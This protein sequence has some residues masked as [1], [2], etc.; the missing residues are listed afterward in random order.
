MST[1]EKSIIGNYIV[2]VADRCVAHLVSIR[3]ANAVTN[4]VVKSLTLAR[5]SAVATPGEITGAQ[6]GAIRIIAI[7]DSG[8]VVT[9][10]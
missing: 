7:T 4:Q 10:V 1:I 3:A 8:P 6:K 5:H 9:R 2:Q